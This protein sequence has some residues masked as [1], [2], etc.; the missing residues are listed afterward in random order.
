MIL[1][2]KGRSITVQPLKINSTTL[3][4]PNVYPVDDRLEVGGHGSPH[5][6]APNLRRTQYSGSITTKT[7]N[8]AT[9]N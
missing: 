5:V 6:Q 2:N 9:M 1:N 4:C 3:E 7:I 8:G